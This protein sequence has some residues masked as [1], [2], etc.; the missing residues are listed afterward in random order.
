MTDYRRGLD[1]RL[2]LLNTYTLIT[3]N[4]NLPITDTR[5]LVYSVY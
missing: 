2:D 5:R 4:Y 1:W 3:P